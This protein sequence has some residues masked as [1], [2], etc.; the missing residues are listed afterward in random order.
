MKI[1]YDWLRRYVNTELDPLQ[2]ASLLTGCGLEV[3]SIGSWSSVKG[4]LE[5]IVTG[6]V[7]T[8]EKHPDSDHLSLTTVDIGEKK[9]LRIVCGAP[10]VAA[11]QKVAVATIGSTLYFRDQ[12]L[13]I[14]KTKIRGEVSEGMICAED[15][16]GLGSSHEGIL[17]LDPSVKPG[18]PA[19]KYFGILTDTV[20]EIGLTPNRPDAASHTGVARDLAAVLKAGSLLNPGSPSANLILPDVSA[21]RPDHQKRTIRI[22]ID[23]PEACPRYTGLTITQVTVKESPAWLRN[24]L[25]SIGLRPIN[26]IVD[27]TNFI[28]HETGQP[29]HAFD[30]DRIKGD[31]VIIRKLPE[32]TPFVTLD[33]V[34]R[35][36]TAD[37]LMI[38][39]AEEPMCIAGVFGGIRSGVTEATTAVFLESAFFNPRSIRRTSRYHGLITDASFR[40]ERGADVNITV[41]AIKRAALMIRE[42]AGGEISS[43]IIDV[44]PSPEKPREIVLSY[45]NLD[46]LVG[47]SIDREI[48]R[49]ILVALGIRILEEKKEYIRVEIPSFKVDVQR[50]ADLIEE[51]L[52]IYGYNNIGFSDEIRSS[53]VLSPKPDPEKLQNLISE[54]L[55]SR[56]FFE[57]ISNSLTKASY[58]EKNGSYASAETV[59]LIN[60]LSRDLNGL[61][62]TML[63]GGLEVIAYNQN[64]QIPDLCLFEFG[65]VYRK[66]AGDKKVENPLD[67]YH[68]EKNLALFMT[69]KA[70]P[71]TWNSD[72][73]NVDFFD[74]KGIFNILMQKAGV[75]LQ[76]LAKETYQ[77]PEIPQ[78]M[79]CRLGTEAV[80]I[81]GSLSGKLLREFDCRQEV[82]YAEIYWERLWKNYSYKILENQELPKYPEVRR[83]LALLLDRS[84]TFDRIRSIAF[85]TEDRLLKKIG[86]FDVYEGDQIEEGK[87]SYAV[88]FV[89]RDDTK[90]L[91]D[92]EIEKVMEKLV[93]AFRERLKAQIR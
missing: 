8:C 31:K 27:I 90:T 47:Q 62:Q 14:R 37:D 65:T 38:C 73:R 11:G 46:R 71:E 44:Y 6:E 1:S 25:N 91:T 74:L 12:E 20:F 7:L 88:S 81:L 17:V 2:V 77:S 41:Y 29:L 13:T 70:R 85:E 66:N 58:F 45:F 33:E 92:A 52:R 15:E 51:I 36:L 28:L 35:K 87:K 82:L 10:N 39:N 55:C 43:D 19:R 56:G 23:D 83:D 49:Q 78:G 40:F 76:N 26:N 84:V 61:R 69:G 63:F 68:E 34:Q 42:I 3:E 16:L 60:P 59:M 32:G 67:K 75:N 64:R 5:G 53:L 21:F 30:A 50:E 48:I 4:G 89:L 18:T 24:R 54:T 22:R 9:P 93:R 57:I 72:R 80:A 86:L 79:I